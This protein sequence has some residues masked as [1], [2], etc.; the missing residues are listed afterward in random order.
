MIEC[1]LKD[2]ISSYSLDFDWIIISLCIPWIRAGGGGGGLESLSE[3]FHYLRI[4]AN[5]TKQ[6]KTRKNLGRGVFDWI[7]CI[8]GV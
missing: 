5:N 4:V 6:K 2:N 3:S 1:L 7:N 8:H